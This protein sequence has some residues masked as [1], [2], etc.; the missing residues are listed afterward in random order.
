MPLIIG[1]S[2]GFP[3][4]SSN[5][6]TARQ[7]YFAWMSIAP[8]QLTWYLP[9]HVSGSLVSNGDPQRGHISSHL[10]CQ[11]R[12]DAQLL[13][14]RSRFREPAIDY[15]PIAKLTNRCL[16]RNGVH[17]EQSFKKRK[18]RRPQMNEP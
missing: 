15:F 12:V 2:I 11:V 4:T 7:I 6:T 3:G 5:M 16:L 8:P 18:D 10:G 17:P 13:G 9:F 14:A 1:R